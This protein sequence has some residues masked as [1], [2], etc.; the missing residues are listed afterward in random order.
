MILISA[1]RYRILLLLTSVSVIFIS[2]NIQAECRDFDAI[3][4][5]NN[6]ALSFFKNAEVF[7]PGVIQKVHNPSGKKEVASY[8]KVGEKRYS[9]FNLV[10][11]NCKVEFRKRTR[12]GD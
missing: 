12:Q 2:E 3:A 9:I 7:H 6:K 4:A 8:I 10:D 11:E 5:A 1:T